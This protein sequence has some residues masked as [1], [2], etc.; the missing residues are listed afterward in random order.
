MAD[1][2]EFREFMLILYR[3]LMMITRWIEKRYMLRK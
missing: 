2:T 1:N 3:A